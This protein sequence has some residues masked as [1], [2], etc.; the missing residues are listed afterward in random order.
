MGLFGRR[1]KGG[2]ADDGSDLRDVPPM[3]PDRFW[4]LVDG[5]R[6][7][8]DLHDRLEELGRHD[9]V[10]FERRRDRLT[11]E[12]YD[13]GLWG[14]AY[15]VH[16]GCSDDSFSDFRA[17]LVSRG[18][19]VFEDA[20]ADPESLA[21]VEELDAEGE[22]WEEWSTPTLT[23][24]H[25]RTGE[26]DFAGPPDPGRSVSDEPSGAEWDEDGDGDD[27]ARR[28]PRLTAKYG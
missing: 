24:V 26:H 9:L 10:A 19:A 3:E 15:D 23:V 7:P 1:S 17:Y 8:S 25:R 2:P 5:V 6:T 14:A 11:D 18:R 22:E 16:G 13:W 20:L 21:D 27:L 12:A 4:A 28:Y